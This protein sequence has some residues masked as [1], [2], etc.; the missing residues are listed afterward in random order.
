MTNDQARTGPVHSVS[1]N[2]RPAR[3]RRYERIWNMGTTELT[4]S[5]VMN[6]LIRGRAAPRPRPEDIGPSPDEVVA[7]VA[8]LVESLPVAELEP[9]RD[10]VFSALYPEV[11]T[12]GAAS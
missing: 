4:H 6:R 9:F 3:Y 1:G 12:A 10:Q 7:A 2:Q 11:D 8:D 5:A